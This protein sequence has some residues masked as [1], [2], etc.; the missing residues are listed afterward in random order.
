MIVNPP[1]EK[2]EACG[3]THSDPAMK[4]A[5]IG[6]DRFC[7]W[8]SLEIEGKPTSFVLHRMPPP[9]IDKRILAAQT[10]LHLWAKQKVDDYAEFNWYSCFYYGKS[11]GK[12]WND[13]LVEFVGIPARIVNS[14]GIP[15][16]YGIVR[17]V[18]VY[19]P[20]AE[21]YPPEDDL[22]ICRAR[23]FYKFSLAYL[24]ILYD[25][26]TGKSRSIE[27][28]Q[29]SSIPEIELVCRGL[30][31][32]YVIKD[33]PG[34]S[35]GTSKTMTRETYLEGFEK[36][37]KNNPHLTKEALASLCSSKSTFYRDR[38]A[39]MFSDDDIEA[40]RSRILNERK[41]KRICS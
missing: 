29:H 17:D 7:S 34:P 37:L 32:F 19:Y 38:K 23:I 40:I 20:S 31:L 2:C 26:T 13:Y 39:R 5:S 3:S 14:V 27:N 35:K 24:Q 41:T 30:E 22:L 8:C 25:R 1:T 33:K 21:F 6:S 15:Q 4:G 28:T 18:P 9:P 16:S 10:S 36:A 11:Y 12:K